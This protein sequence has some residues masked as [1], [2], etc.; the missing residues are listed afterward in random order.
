MVKKSFKSKAE[1]Q[2]LKGIRTKKKKGKK[3]TYSNTDICQTDYR[4]ESTII[5]IQRK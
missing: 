2:I 4:D 1:V 3:S 5:R